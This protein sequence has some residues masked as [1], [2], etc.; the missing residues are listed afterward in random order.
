MDARN[1][2]LVVAL[3]FPLILGACS[4]DDST[5]PGDGGNDDD[6]GSDEWV[7]LVDENN[8]ADWTDIDQQYG[9]DLCSFSGGVLRVESE[10]GI[11]GMRNSRIVITSKH[12]DF[13]QYSQARIQF[14]LRAHHESGGVTRLVDVQIISHVPGTPGLRCCGISLSA[15]NPN[16]P[17]SYFKEESY[18]I[19][20]ENALGI[21]DATIKVDLLQ[22][23]Y[24]DYYNPG[25]DVWGELVGLRVMVKE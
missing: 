9:N 25:S 7:V 5:G 11:H 16:P 15:Y 23:T 18:D 17:S 22:N 19:S 24:E 8:P 1:F 21:S 6:N 4:S 14:T 3:I 13:T 20:L 10:M 2:R 12:V